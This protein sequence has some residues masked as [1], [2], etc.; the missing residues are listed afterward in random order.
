MACNASARC[1]YLKTYPR[2][3]R[4]RRHNPLAGG[5]HARD[6]AK[7]QP[8]QSIR[9][10]ERSRPAMACKACAARLRMSGRILSCEP[11]RGRCRSRVRWHR[12]FQEPGERAPRCRQCGS[13]SSTGC[14]EPRACPPPRSVGH[15]PSLKMGIMILSALPPEARTIPVR[16][17]ARRNAHLLES[18]DASSV[19]R[20]YDRQEIRSGRA[21]FVEPFIAAHTIKPDRRPLNEDPGRIVCLFDGGGQLLG[22]VHVR[23]SRSFRLT[24]D[25]QRSS[26]QVVTGK[27][28]HGI[29]AIERSP[30]PEVEGSPGTM[31]KGHISRR[32]RTAS[33]FRERMTGS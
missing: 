9:R 32:R 31:R 24:S 30:R 22:A 10:S 28:D 25:V 8:Q 6:F 18:G 13:S 3:T 12:R 1:G 27:I 17:Q 33:A 21:R 15:G 4:L 29:T 5:D 11:V 2:A 20:R 26:K 23:L 16:T 19:S 7:H 14:L